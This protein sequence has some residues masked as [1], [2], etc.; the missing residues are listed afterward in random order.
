MFCK[1]SAWHLVRYNVLFCLSQPSNHY[2]WKYQNPKNQTM[3]KKNWK[4]ERDP[5]YLYLKRWSEYPQSMRQCYNHPKMKNR[6]NEEDALSRWETRRGYTCIHDEFGA[7]NGATGRYW[8]V[9]SDAKNGLVMDRVHVG[10]AGKKQ[11]DFWWWHDWWL[12]SRDWSNK[13]NVGKVMQSKQI[14][15][16]VACM[17]RLRCETQWRKGWWKSALH[18]ITSRWVGVAY[19]IEGHKR[20]VNEFIKSNSPIPSPKSL[21]INHHARTHARFH[22]RSRA[23]LLQLCR[24]P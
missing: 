12:I 10:M 23:F 6:M 4:R 22:S 24:L 20:T 18:H 15:G 16:V 8:V 7:L 5:R 1:R 21:W 11:L 3:G 2:Q 19:F 9:S 17:S 14:H 13:K